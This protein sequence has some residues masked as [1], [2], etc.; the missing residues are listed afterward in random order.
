[1][2]FPHGHHAKIPRGTA[3]TPWICS[4]PP[5]PGRNRIGQS[6]SH[7]LGPRSFGR[8]GAGRQPLGQTLDAALPQYSVVISTTTRTGQVLAANASAEPR[9]LLPLDLPGLSVPG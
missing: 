1:V 6:A 9:F 3:G 5:S 7:H 4:I 2:A 8:R